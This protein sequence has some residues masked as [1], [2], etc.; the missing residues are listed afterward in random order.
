MAKKLNT[1]KTTVVTPAPIAAASSAAPLGKVP[2]GTVKVVAQP[3]RVYN[4]NSARAIYW[5]I[6]NDN[7]GKPADIVCKA[8]QSNPVKNKAPM[9]HFLNWFVKRGQ[10]TIA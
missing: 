9:G 2:S 10:V 4:P 7:D 1:T 8:M 6:I 3:K 5:Q